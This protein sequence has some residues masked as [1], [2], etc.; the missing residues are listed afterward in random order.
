MGIY[1]ELI[2]K[3]ETSTVPETKTKGKPRFK[4]H[5]TENRMTNLGSVGRN[6]GP[7]SEGSILG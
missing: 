1:K 7:Q 6:L 2:P 5:N 4:D 3:D